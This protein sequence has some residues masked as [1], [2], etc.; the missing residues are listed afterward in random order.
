MGAKDYIPGG[1]KGFLEW[2]RKLYAHAAENFNRWGVENP[3][4]RIAGL[5]ADYETKY[6]AAA[7]PNRGKVDVTAKTSA[8][9]ALEKAC[10]IYVQGFLARN[11]NVSDADRAIMGVT[12][13]DAKPSAVNP[14]KLPAKGDLHYPGAGLVEIRNIRTAGGHP[15]ARADYGARIYYGILGEP[16]ERGRFRVYARPTTGEDL[17]HSVFT[18]QKRRSFDF[19]GDSGKEVYFCIRFE[20]G[21]GQPGP[22]GDVLKTYIP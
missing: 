3:N 19:T 2:A 9:N 1:D 13:R 14:P 12:V 22:W 18:R 17:P 8:R 21:K 15:D 10:R 20:N 11:P 16:G 7:S 4:I 5:L 6:A